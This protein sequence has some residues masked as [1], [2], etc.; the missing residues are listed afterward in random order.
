MEIRPTSNTVLDQV[1]IVADKIQPL[2]LE[3]RGYDD[4][5]VNVR[6]GILIK[7]G[8][9]VNYQ[10]IRDQAKIPLMR[11]NLK[12]L[13]L[14]ADIGLRWPVQAHAE[15]FLWNAGDLKVWRCSWDGEN[16]EKG[17]FTFLGRGSNSIP[18]SSVNNFQ[19]GGQLSTN[20]N[21]E[22]TNM[23][24]GCGLSSLIT[25]EFWNSCSPNLRQGWLIFGFILSMAKD[26]LRRVLPFRS[27]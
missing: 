6:N 22:I 15:C 20:Q 18:I 1:N 11:K 27:A 23:L 5:G 9:L 21:G 8:N 16:V 4:E 25:K 14:L 13:L 26:S 24:E 17:I 10:A 7:D 3:I 12:R 19:F 2:S